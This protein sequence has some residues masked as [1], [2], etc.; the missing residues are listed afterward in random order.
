[1]NKLVCLNAENFYDEDRANTYFNSKG[2]QAF[3]VSATQRALELLDL[4]APSLVL[5]LGSGTGISMATLEANG[6]TAFG[7][8]AS[9]AMVAVSKE[10]SQK[11]AGQDRFTRRSDESMA[12][13]ATSIPFRKESFDAAVGIESL[14]WLCVATVRTENVQNKVEQFFAKLFSVLV[15]G[16]RAAFLIGASK[17]AKSTIV[18]LLLKGALGAGFAARIVVDNPNSRKKKLTW[19]ELAVGEL[20]RMGTEKY[21]DELEKEKKKRLTNKQKVSKKKKHNSIKKKRGKK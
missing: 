2:A 3:Q 15:Y 21:V 7:L 10:L 11:L 18:E 12:N 4:K 20:S 6:H 13:F 1:M 16:S 9:A 5:D 19:L 8:D 17:D 14:E